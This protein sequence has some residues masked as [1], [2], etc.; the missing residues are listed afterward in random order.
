HR[1]GSYP[2]PRAGSTGSWLLPAPA[3]GSNWIEPSLRKTS[4][5]ASGPSLTDRAGA[6]RCRATRNRRAASAETSMERTL[7]PRLRRQVEDHENGSP[8]ADSN[9][10]NRRLYHALE[11]LSLATPQRAA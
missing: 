8:M 1:A 7:A 2:A 10:R 3:I 6:R 11:G 5:T 9:R 4:R